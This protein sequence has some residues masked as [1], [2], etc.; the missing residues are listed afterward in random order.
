MA[1]NEFLH[2]PL[3]EIKHTTQDIGLGI[4]RHWQPLSLTVAVLA[5]AGYAAYFLGEPFTRPLQPIQPR[6]LITPEGFVPENPNSVEGTINMLMRL[7]S[8]ANEA[9]GIRGSWTRAGTKYRVGSNEESIE[10]I[11]AMNQTT[12]ENIT[13]LNRL[14]YAFDPNSL[15]KGEV[16]SIPVNPV[17]DS[18]YGILFDRISNN[19]NTLRNMDPDSPEAKKLADSMIASWR[20]APGRNEPNNPSQIVV[21]PEA[22]NTEQIE[23]S[24]K[25]LTEAFPTSRLASFVIEPRWPDWPAPAAI[26]FYADRPA[27][28]HIFDRY[29]DPSSRYQEDWTPAKVQKNALLG[30]AAVGNIYGEEWARRYL[31]NEEWMMALLKDT[32]ALD[33][34]YNLYN[35]QR[36]FPLSEKDEFA[37][38]LVSI[39]QGYEDL[40]QNS[41]EITLRQ[42]RFV[43]TEELYRE[44]LQPNKIDFSDIARQLSQK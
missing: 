24:L 28:I 18:F 39:L 14:E 42:E 34:R 3:R 23:K 2:Q 9:K 17:P 29:S 44:M 8:A 35:P 4:R 33:K 32:R 25:Q 16:L 20:F 13:Q 11:A 37:F 40:A 43:N 1:L 36:I 30:L 5:I 22:K 27:V 21:S 7:D 41:R 12:P 26:S 38:S 6:G 31:T 19:L 15:F 10:N